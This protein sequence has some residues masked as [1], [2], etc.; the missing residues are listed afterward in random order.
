MKIFLVGGAVRD[1]LLHFP[2][3]E[4]DWVVVGSS[5]EEMMQL[6]Y[7]PVGKDFP[8][9]LHP[10]SHEEY[11]LARTERKTAR[12]YKGFTF[13]TDGNVTLEEDLQRRDL[14]INA[15]AQDDNGT[16]IDPYNGQ[17][18]IKDKWLRH[19]S[20]AFSEDPVRVLRVARFA[21]RYH[22]LGFR[23][24]EETLALMQVMA[25]NGETQHLVPERVWQECQKALSEQYPEIFFTSLKDSHTL[26][27]ILPN[28]QH[29]DISP[30][31]TALNS[32]CQLTG[33]PIMRFAAFCFPLDSSE[34]E[35]LCLHLAT[36]NEYKELAILSQQHYLTCISIN[37][38]SAVTL[39]TLFQKTDA[40]RKLERFKKLL[41][42]C[43]AIY[44]MDAHKN[45]S[46]EFE[47]VRLLLDALQSYK[48]IDHQALIKQGFQKAALGEAIK[49]KRLTQ[50]HQ[51]LKTNTSREQ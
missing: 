21:A 40:L 35:T 39:T 28:F 45:Q 31:L 4:K 11:A 5:P 32:C 30:C 33:D 2:Y 47:S 44:H 25:S 17:Q 14:T 9:F 22:H 43:Q 42:V 50:L 36:P 29:N 12:G 8:V 18:D 10:Q 6:G 3:H 24:A 41:I 19:V 15:I 26:N 1:Q 48:N 13:H 34:T 7:T 51:W 16:I 37:N 23:V 46:Q 49:E 20:S 27:D 38:W